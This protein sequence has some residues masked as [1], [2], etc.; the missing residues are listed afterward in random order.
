MKKNNFEEWTKEELIKEIDQLKKRKKYGLVWEVANEEIVEKCINEFP[1]IELVKNK[2][3]YKK[4]CQSN[5][6][7]IEGDNFHSLSVLNYTHKKKIDVIYIDPPYNTGSRDWKYNNN[8]VDEEDRFRHSKWCSFMYNRLKL[9]KDL[10]TDDGIVIA[11]IDNNEFHNLRHIL[12]EIFPNK[13]IVTTV[14]QHNFRGRAKNN[15][16]LTH[17]YLI[18]VL[19]ANKDIITREDEKSADG[20]LNLRRTGQNSLK[21]DRP[22]MFYGILV[23][24]KLKIIGVTEVLK[25]S[26]DLNKLKKRE[27]VKIVLPIDKEGTERRWYYG[28][29][30]TI[31]E[32]K[33]GN[34]FATI[35]KDKIEIKFKF[36]GIPKRRKSVWTDPKYDSSSH[37]TGL[38]NEILGKDAF[39]FP[40]SLYAVKDCIEAATKKKNAI[41]LDFFAGSG[42]TGH[43]VL[44]LNEMDSGNREFILCTNNEK[45]NS[46]T[47][48]IA[49]D[50]TYPR[51]K[52]VIEGYKKVKGIKCNLKYFKTKFIAADYNDKNKILMA[53][54]ATDLICVK[55]NVYELVLENSDYKIFKNENKFVFIIYN[56]LSIEKIVKILTKYKGQIKLYIFSL[57]IDFFEDEFKDF[58]NVEV[59]PIPEPIL[60]TYR[61][62]FY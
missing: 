60:A 44:K 19:P 38:L 54:N 53:K 49:E 27:N 51:L 13:E 23:N 32:A 46:G 21:K 17:E 50:I 29:E 43:A 31:E 48:K 15:F 4:N 12:E 16:S 26:N 35:I 1:I 47:Y 11:S 41:I 61:R 25:S 28:S 10:L 30:R 45:T 5:G 18:W 22:T 37:G 59:E 56:Q 52:K 24:D 6:I 2:Q 3:I 7:I 42:T 9:T 34:V 39:P 36:S 14:I 57:G 55:E 20:I 8:Y 58:S 62:I 33:K 40:K